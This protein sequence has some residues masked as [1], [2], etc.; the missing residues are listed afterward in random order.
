V[1]EVYSRQEID[2][3]KAA[4]KR[5]LPPV[6]PLKKQPITYDSKILVVDDSSTVRKILRRS[7]MEFGFETE[8]IIEAEDGED[9]LGVLME[10]EGVALIVTDVNMP[11]IDGL[12]LIAHLMKNKEYET[13]N[14]LLLTGESNEH[15][16]AEADK[17]GVEIFIKPFK[18]EGFF[19]YLIKMMVD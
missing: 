11:K 16:K 3:I 17:Y 10:H 8:K 19:T 2:K 13:I 7:F 12:G 6:V 14:I 9:A 15:L 18:K 4:I 5:S 1:L